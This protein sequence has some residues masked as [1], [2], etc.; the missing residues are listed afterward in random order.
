ML[1]LAL[2]LAALAVATA[3]GSATA[4]A[5]RLHD[6]HPCPGQTGFTCSMLTVALD[7]T[8]GQRGS[9]R[10]AVAAADSERAPRGFLLFLTGGPGQ[11][12][13]FAAS[14]AAEFLGDVRDSYRIVTYDQRGTGA[15]ALRCP[16]LQA[17]MGSSDLYPP[18]A[19]A[20]RA[21]GAAVGARRNLYGTDDVVADMDDLRIA[22]GADRL[23]LDGVS[24]G[25]YVAE[26]YAIAHPEHV[27][28]L[29]LDSVVPHGAGPWLPV[30]PFPE[31]A[32]VLRSACADALA[33]STRADLAALVRRGTARASSTRS[34]C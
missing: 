18:T 21:C 19:A 28:R 7:R 11:P 27:A 31:V 24:Y 20:V 5:P 15:T 3:D 10:L 25:T 33:A 2:V 30:E 23:T 29:V 17:A 34:R 4:A 8:G 13:V 12:G 22:L 9:L 14:R 1:R 6:A 26:R 16:G 32:R